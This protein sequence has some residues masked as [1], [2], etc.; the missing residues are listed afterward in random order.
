M[1]NIFKKY[2]W[3]G[4]GGILLFLALFI[5]K[6]T[7]AAFWDL[8]D[9]MAGSVSNGITHLIFGSLTM[10]IGGVLTL[11]LGLATY[12]VTFVLELNFKLLDTTG[13]AYNF[14][15]VG[16]T[17]MR[18]IANLGFVLFII[19]IALA[20]IV[21]FRDYEAKQL[22][23]RLIGA[24]ILVNFSLAIPSIFINFSD[25][26]SNYF[27]NKIG[28]EQNEQGNISGAAKFA[29]SLDAIANPATILTGSADDV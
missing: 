12:F 2:S 29:L 14:I 19:I 13:G 5:P 9:K 15:S 7:H 26:L 6:T 23:P 27:L 25:V 1:K 22:L 17:I 11:L 8:A 24:A 21:R 16:W 10:I 3:K 18:D 4:I 28:L 20:T